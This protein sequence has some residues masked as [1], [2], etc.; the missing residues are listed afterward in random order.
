V[1]DV[2]TEFLLDLKADLDWAGAMDVATTQHDTRIIVCVTGG[3][4]EVA[5]VKGVLLPR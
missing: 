5:K 3:L 4:V 2:E 1:L